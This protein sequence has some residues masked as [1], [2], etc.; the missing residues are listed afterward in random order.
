MKLCWLWLITVLSF[1]CFS[2]IPDLWPHE[3]SPHRSEQ[4][5]HIPPMSPNLVST[6]YKTSFILN[7]KR[8][9]LVS[10][11]G[12]LPQLLD[13]QHFGIPYCCALRKWCLEKDQHWWTPVLSKAFSMGSLLVPWAIWSLFPSCS[14]LKFCW[15]FSSYQQSI[16][17]L[18][19]AS[20]GLRNSPCSVECVYTRTN[21]FDE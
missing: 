2:I 17:V 14:G 12:L 19:W 4:H 20:H 15:L 13:F 11:A 21:H 8:R 5:Q 1:R 3:F 16:L 7:S 9:S 10:K 6:G 18:S